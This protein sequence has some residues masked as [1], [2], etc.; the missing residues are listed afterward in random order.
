MMLQF[1]L[2]LVPSAFTSNLDCIQS[3]SKLSNLIISSLNENQSDLTLTN[4]KTLNLSFDS[5]DT[6]FIL[7]L[8]SNDP[9]VP[10]VVQIWD[11]VELKDHDHNVLTW[12]EANSSNGF[13][14]LTTSS[15][16]SGSPDLSGF[17]AI[18]IRG[19]IHKSDEIYE[20]TTIKEYSS[21]RRTCDIPVYQF[22][23]GD[24]LILLK[25]HSTKPYFQNDLGTMLFKRDIPQLLGCGVTDD[26]IQGH[27]N[28]QSKLSIND[29]QKA[30]TCPL[31]TKKLLAMGVAAD[32][33]YTLQ[34][35]GV[36][37]SLQQIL[38]TWNSASAVYESTFNIQLGVAKVMLQQS[39]SLPGDSMNWNVGCSQNYS[40]TSRLSDFSKW[41]GTQQD[42]LGLY[43]LMTAC[44]TQP[45]VGIAWLGTLCQT[46]ASQQNM[47][48]VPSFVSGTGVSSIVPV[49]W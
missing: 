43:H 41:R 46:T 30:S 10:L 4:G 19:S 49:Q 42:S 23:N 34:K 32:C 5:F 33:S 8:T 21:S 44:A 11:G 28:L 22:D 38:T 6:K 25:A 45:A 47:G 15:S 9:K 35:G 2:M 36:S 26:H 27:L 18:H 31:P 37:Q 24:D 17:G 7:N 12:R 40:I 48:G 16:S 1:L 20:I 29:S 14:R 3:Y 13:I 39:C